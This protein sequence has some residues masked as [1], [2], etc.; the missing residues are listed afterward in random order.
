VAKIAISI[1]LVVLATLALATYL[2]F[3]SL[4]LLGD[5]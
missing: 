4:T 5:G 3:I 1:A 2:P